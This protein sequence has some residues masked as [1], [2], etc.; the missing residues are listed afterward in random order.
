MVSRIHFLTQFDHHLVN[1]TFRPKVHKGLQ[2]GLKSL[3][4]LIYRI[5]E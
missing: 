2:M 3:D 4:E 1:L 5:I